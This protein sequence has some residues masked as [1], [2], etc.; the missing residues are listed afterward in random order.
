VNRSYGYVDGRRRVTVFF[1]KKRGGRDFGLKD[2]GARTLT[3]QSPA[4]T[5]A[6]IGP[7]RYRSAQA[8][9]RKRKNPPPSAG[10]KELTET[11]PPAI[12]N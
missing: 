12:R 3:T 8:Q 10:P 6:E 9:A 2:V 4:A 5:Y 7:S 1:V 11:A